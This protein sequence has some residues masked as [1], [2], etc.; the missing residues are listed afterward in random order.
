MIGFLKENPEI[1]HVHIFLSIKK[2]REVDS[3][4]L[5]SWLFQN[6]HQVYTSIMEEGKEE[7]STV[8]IFPDSELMEDGWGIPVPKAYQT[9]NPDKIQLV[10]IPLLAYD[11]RGHRLGYGK[12]FY[13]KFLYGLKQKVYKVGVSFFQ[14]VM[15]IP[16]EGHDIPLDVCFLPDGEIKFQG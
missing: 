16:H 11:H 1:R 7:M 2:L 6:G 15:H 5:L 14:P 10:V 9:C 8:R 4:E 3:S 12:G 13:D